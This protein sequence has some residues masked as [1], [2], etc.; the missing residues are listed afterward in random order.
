MTDANCIILADTLRIPS[1]VMTSAKDVSGW[2]GLSSE[3]K[4]SQMVTWALLNV[5]EC[6]LL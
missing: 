4:S 6:I 3:R 5:I 2:K 1:F